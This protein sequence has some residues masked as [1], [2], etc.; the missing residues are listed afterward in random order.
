MLVLPKLFIND[1]LEE[2]FSLVN[3]DL[4]QIS[5][6]IKVKLVSNEKTGLLNMLNMGTQF[7]RSVQGLMA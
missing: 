6:V 5:D 4:V 7:H 1:Q 3:L 2:N